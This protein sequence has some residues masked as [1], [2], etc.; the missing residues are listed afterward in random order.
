[1]RKFLIGCLVASGL[2]WGN[3]CGSIHLSGSMSGT[4]YVS[5]H[6]HFSVP[7]PVSPEVHGRVLRDTPE[8]VTFHDNWGSQITFCSAEFSARSSMTAVLQKEG[9]QKALEAFAREEYGESIM[10]HYH[11]EAR[12]G[13]ITLIFL[14]P[15]G[16][17]TG[18]AAFLSGDRVYWVAT[19]L[20][21][22]VQLLSQSDDASQRDRDDW[23]EHRALELLET[24]QLR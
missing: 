6:G 3:G 21:P 11:A 20:L 9:R 5:A 8:S 23:L 1:M 17:K 16:P 2:L 19:D 12:E 18:V 22:G 10:P 13:A 15:V 7:F 24:M 14:R 4:D